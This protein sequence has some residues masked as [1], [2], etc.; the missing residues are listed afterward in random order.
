MVN[1]ETMEEIEEKSLDLLHSCASSGIETVKDDIVEFLG[2]LREDWEPIGEDYSEGRFDR[3]MILER[4]HH[5]WWMKTQFL[6]EG[7]FE[8]IGHLPN[9]FRRP[10][11]YQN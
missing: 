11:N 2:D 6:P 8:K 10:E 9:L 1:Y 4:E 3:L 7:M 5:F